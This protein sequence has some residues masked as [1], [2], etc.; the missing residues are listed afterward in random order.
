MGGGNKAAP[1][2]LC[3]R[4][5]S[6]AAPQ[7]GFAHPAARN[8]DISRRKRALPH[9]G[10]DPRLLTTPHFHLLQSFAPH[11]QSSPTLLGLPAPS[12]QGQ[13]VLGHFPPPV[14]LPIAEGGKAEGNQA[15]GELLLSGKA[16][17]ISG[18]SWP[19]R[20]DQ[21]QLPGPVGTGT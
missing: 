5:G 15:A 13:G 8:A 14:N 21:H 19:E 11:P 4:L 7:G 16:L 17:H 10:W 18:R 3:A 2:G 1:G 6:K 20:L 12:N 9:A